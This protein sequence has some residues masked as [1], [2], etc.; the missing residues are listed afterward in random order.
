MPHDF[1]KSAGVVVKN[2]DELVKVL[3]GTG[4]K[5]YKGHTAEEVAKDALY[6]KAGSG[7]IVID[8]GAKI[9]GKN[10]SKKINSGYGKVQ[11]RIADF[12]IKAGS[13]I[14]DALKSK[15]EAAR[16]T[17]NQRLRDFKREGKFSGLSET[18]RR[19]QIKSILKIKNQGGL[20]SKIGN[21]F[22]FKHQFPLSASKKGKIDNI[23]EVGVPALTAPLE[24]SKKIILPMAG[25][26]AINAKLTDM[27]SIGKEEKK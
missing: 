10:L 16:I 27:Q 19:K 3:R 18:E 4:K 11:N 6:G 9:F 12:D 15:N 7:S 24:K 14:H 2:F 21:A 20:R 26:L 13:K 23:V 25:A 22:V 1:E 5:F 8:Y 17:A